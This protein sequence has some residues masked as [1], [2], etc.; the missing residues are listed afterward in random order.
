ML[1]AAIATVSL[2]R[3]SAGHAIVQKLCEAS[4]AGFDG[5]EIFFECLEDLA[6]AK[7]QHPW[8]EYRATLLAAAGKIR[9]VCDVQSLKVIALQPFVFYDGLVDTE[10]RT[11][12]I[13]L[14]KLWFELCHILGTDLIQIPTNFQ[15]LGTT[16]DI[17]RI[18]AD[19]S[20]VAS[21]GLQERP[22]I[23]FAYEGISWGTHIDTWE[24]TWD[25]V[26][27]V[28]LPNLGLC[29]D[30]FHIAGRVWADPTTDSGQKAQADAALDKSLKRLVS[31]VDPAK[32]F[33]VQLSDAERLMPP[34]GKTHHFYVQ[35]Q[36][37]RM[38]WS[39]NARLFPFE[40][41]RGAYLPIARICRAIFVQLK[42]QGWVSMEIFSQTLYD[43]RPETPRCHASRAA[44]SWER[45]FQID[46]DLVGSR[47]R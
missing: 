16:G 25:I 4:A 12:K 26:K 47:I 17:D 41:D 22:P 30:T 1:K 42:W 9:Q 43:N 15:S 32:I 6:G 31:D 23:R 8:L 18:T 36:K 24:G 2:G 45:I 27:R 44:R 3:S 7:S 29:L 38:S 40:T 5:V 11:Q 10:A 46:R 33:Y 37:P 13:D 19:L 21:L 14:S 28:N 20:L 35:D 34:L 39:R